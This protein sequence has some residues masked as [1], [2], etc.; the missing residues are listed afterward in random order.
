MLR[1]LF[2]GVKVKYGECR[3]KINEDTDFCGSLSVRAQRMRLLGRV[4]QMIRY[5]P[6]RR[7]LED[8]TSVKKKK[9]HPKLLR[10]EPVG[11]LS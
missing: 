7:L 1:K 10:T 4:Y 5:R 8:G 11:G 3:R 9:G 2:G 6:A